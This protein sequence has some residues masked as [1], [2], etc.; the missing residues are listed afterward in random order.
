MLVKVLLSEELLRE[1]TISL[2]SE[3]DYCAVLFSLLETMNALE[4]TTV[5]NALLEL[6]LTIVRKYS[7]FPSPPPSPSL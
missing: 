6:L 4:E 5:A 7:I 1:D 3:Y 2:I